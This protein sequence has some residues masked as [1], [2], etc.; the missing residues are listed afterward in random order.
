M[1]DCFALLNESR[2]PWL[3]AD[4]LKQ[5]FLTLTAQVHPDRVHAGTEAEKGA[6]QARYTELNAAYNCLRE[7]KQRLLHLIELESGRK[8]EQ[9]QVIPSRLMN[10]FMEI[11]RLCR[12]VDCFLA[13]KAKAASPLL[14]VQLFERSEEWS[15]KLAA[16]RERIR[17]LWD[18]LESELKHLD[19]DWGASFSSNAS[20]RAGLLQRSEELYRLFSYVTRWNAQ[21]QERVIQLSL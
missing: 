14:L 3:D 12:E 18:E 21:I 15:T 20:A 16:L 8:P 19:K 7:P 10:F 2:R 11:S 4:L 9:V 13:E 6:A 5:K 1:I 17:P